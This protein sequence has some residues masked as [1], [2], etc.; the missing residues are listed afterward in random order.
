MR[1]RGGSPI[2]QALRVAAAA[3]RHRP[4][5]HSHRCSGMALELVPVDLMDGSTAT[6][7][8]RQNGAAGRQPHAP[9]MILEANLPRPDADP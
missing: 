5:R 1:D 6:Y 4:P 3:G 9:S 2:R 7:A 8:I